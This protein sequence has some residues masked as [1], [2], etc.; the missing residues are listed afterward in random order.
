M[1]G[2]RSISAK[3]NNTAHLPPPYEARET[4]GRIHILIGTSMRLEVGNPKWA[5]DA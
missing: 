4:V 2:V 1:I 5:A 3:K